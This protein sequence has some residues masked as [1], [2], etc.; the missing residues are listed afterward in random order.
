[1]KRMQRSEETLKQPSL[2]AILGLATF[3][4]YI[5]VFYEW[6]FI[7]TKPSFLSGTSL[8]E[9]FDTLLIPATFFALI[10]FGISL[11]CWLIAYLFSHQRIAAFFHLVSLVVSALIIASLIF[12]LLDDFTYTAFKHGVIYVR[13]HARLLY[14][15]FF[16]VLFACTLSMFWNF[17]C[18]PMSKL[19]ACIFICSTLLLPAVGIG[20][21]IDKFSKLTPIR[22]YKSDRSFKV[23]NLPDIFIIG[24]DA[25][26]A[27]HLSVYGFER[28]TTPF[29]RS[30]A[31]EFIIFRNAFVG[32]PTSAGSLLSMLSGNET[33]AT[34]VV[35][36]PD[37][38]RGKHSHSHFLAMLR[39]LGYRMFE[40]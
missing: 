23:K 37:I 10:S 13:S 35:H 7:V 22:P 25:L 2:V 18:S 30:I 40:F 1:M 3:S 21:A 27:S 32:T 33:A 20:V 9:H 38:V 19:Y 5:F 34:Q 8:R 15:V 11:L 24:S 16:F 6:L 31:N 39:G 14:G 28:D 36:Y 12:N 26:E 29:L 17:V 4:S